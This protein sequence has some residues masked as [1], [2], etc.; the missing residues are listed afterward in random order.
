MAV[1]LFGDWEKATQI[2]GTMQQ[3][4]KLAGDRALMREAHFFRKMIVEGMREQAP[5][6]ERFKPLSPLTLLIRR[7]QGFKGTKALIRRADLRNSIT[8]TRMDSAVFVG[9]LRSAKNKNG[10]SLVN[11]ATI[12][13][14]G[15]G[16]VIIPITAKSR[17][18]LHMMARKAGFAF[19]GGR[20]GGENSGHTIAILRIPA[21]PFFR[22]VFEKYGQPNDV[23]DRFYASIANEMA[24]DFGTPD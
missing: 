8:I 13:E 19:I 21:R 12:H 3:K 1:K 5:G 14:Y 20:G 9:I 2:V 10:Q 11:V 4:F 23:R 6:G 18:Y 24:G 22:P 15:L 16:P 17:A 7:A